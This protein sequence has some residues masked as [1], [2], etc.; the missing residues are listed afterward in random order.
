[1]N[2][3]ALLSVTTTANMWLVAR[4]HA[5][6]LGVVLKDKGSTPSLYIVSDF[7]HC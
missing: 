4:D 3:I 7:M 1:M 2:P 6:P 5:L